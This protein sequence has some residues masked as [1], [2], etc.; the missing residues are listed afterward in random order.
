LYC[1]LADALEKS[2]KKAE[3]LPYCRRLADEFEKGL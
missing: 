2:E 3:A 1:N